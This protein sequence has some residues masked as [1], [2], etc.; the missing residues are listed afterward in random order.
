MTFSQ[1]NLEFTSIKKKENLKSKESSCK[2]LI[3]TS[4]FTFLNLQIFL[5][6]FL[7]SNLKLLWRFFIDFLL[8]LCLNGFGFWMFLDFDLTFFTDKLKIVNALFQL[9]NNPWHFW[10]I[11]LFLSFLNSLFVNFIKCFLILN[12]LFLSFGSN[13]A[14]LHWL[15]L[16]L[17][18]FLFE[19]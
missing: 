18:L 4:E 13:H 9:V 11:L 2:W 8:F 1:S 16:R 10:R 15:F 5:F 3:D 7:F 14:L 17:L 6:A 12:F 19:S